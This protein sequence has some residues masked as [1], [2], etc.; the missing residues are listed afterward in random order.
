MANCGL[1][2]DEQIKTEFHYNI[3]RYTWYRQ[4]YDH[5]IELRVC[6]YVK[7]FET[8]L[9]VQDDYSETD[10]G[11]RGVKAALTAASETLEQKRHAR[12]VELADQIRRVPK[13]R[14]IS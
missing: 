3:G 9:L 12:E 6:A 11:E 2:N 14:A 7:R 4:D 10:V 8:W 5:W 1:R 13:Q